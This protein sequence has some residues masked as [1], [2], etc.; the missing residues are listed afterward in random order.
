MIQSVFVIPMDPE[1][2]KVGNYYEFLA[3]RRR[4][5]ADAANAFLDHLL[6]GQV[7]DIEQ[8]VSVLDREQVVLQGGVDGEDEEL[9]LLQCS[10]WVTEQ[11]LAEGELLYELAE[12]DTG[13]PLA[14]LDLAWPNGL[15]E[16]LGQPVAVL[17]DEG[18]EVEAIASAQGYRF[19]TSVESFKQY[20][21][22]EVLV[23]EQVRG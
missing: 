9:E 14:I 16:G 5:L 3:E 21:N 12:E 1:L 7:P 11:S 2:W 20:V 6:A 19:F 22:R 8:E 10:E 4:L 23:L 17:L 13:E 18:P 15:Q